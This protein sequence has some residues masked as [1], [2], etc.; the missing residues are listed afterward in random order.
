MSQDL[1]LVSKDEIESIISKSVELGVSKALSKIRFQSEIPSLSVEDVC[2]ITGYSVQTI[3][4][5]RKAG[6][7]KNVRK[8]GRRYKY[9]ES[10]I[11][12]LS[13]VKNENFSRN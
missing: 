13:G 9:S 11:A 10:E 6:K 7:L 12:Q 8:F 3:N 4:N 1:I 2:E 5:M